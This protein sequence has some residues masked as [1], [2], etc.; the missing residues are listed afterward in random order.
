MLP[1]FSPGGN[2]HER[3]GEYAN[4]LVGLYGAEMS[5]FRAVP[6]FP[7]STVMREISYQFSGCLATDHLPFYFVCFLAVLFIFNVLQF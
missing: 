3:G 2:L 1:C 5:A 6:S 4:R 7:T